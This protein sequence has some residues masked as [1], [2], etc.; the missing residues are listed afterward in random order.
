[1]DSP[2]NPR[3]AFAWEAVSHLRQA[4]GTV[5]ADFAGTGGGVGLSRVHWPDNG[6][7]PTNGTTAERAVGRTGC[8]SEPKDA[9]AERIV[10]NLSRDNV[11]C[12][13]KKPLEP[14]VD[15]NTVKEGPREDWLPTVKSRGEAPTS[16]RGDFN[17]PHPSTVI[18]H[19]QQCHNDQNRDPKIAVFRQVDRR[20]V[21]ARPRATVPSH[22]NVSI[23][24]D[25]AFKRASPVFLRASI[26]GL[27][28]FRWSTRTKRAFG[29]S[30]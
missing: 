16:L 23:Q 27:A 11:V 3:G 4:L 13:V 18:Q 15:Q 8:N 28:V 22:F 17:T 26:I 21:Q 29:R 2:R 20:M 5:A 19:P 25:V 12:E 10:G 9:S 1:V 24:H 7:W 30:W 6:D 14:H